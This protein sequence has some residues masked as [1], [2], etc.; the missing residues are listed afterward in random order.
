MREISYYRDLLFI[1][2]KKEIKV[3]YKNSYFG[4]LWSLLN[5]LAFA[6]IFYF[7][8]GMIMRMQMKDY[9]LFLITGL[10]PWQWISNSVLA[11]TTI[12]ISNASIIK[13][14]DFPR[15]I[16]PLAN[17]LQD[18][19]HFICAIP[20]IIIFLL[21]YK[22]SPSWSWLYGIPVLLVIQ[23]LM[24]YGLSMVCS[25]LNLFFRDLQQI[26]AILM[27][28]AFYPTPILYPV[29]MIPEKYRHLVDLNI[30]TPIIICWREMFLHGSF[31]FHYLSLAA[32][33]SIVSWLSGFLLYKKL[34]Y[35]F[36]EVI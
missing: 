27:M 30:F 6:F 5:P 10:F 32:T 13:K 36:A 29:S 18:M 14:I 1:L 35:R 3:R 21:M 12:Y 34:R 11:S 28:F 25:S 15:N 7:V 2:T 23:C 24:A 26:V 22:E 19:F 31:D 9:S 16:L 8:F 17:T 20:I 33:Y 4:Y